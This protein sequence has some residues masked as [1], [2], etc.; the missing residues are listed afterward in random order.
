VTSVTFETATIADAIRRAARIAP[1]KAGHAFDKAAG[2]FMEID[3]TGD[4]QC[5][6]RATNIEAFHTEVIATVASDGEP[7]RWRLPSMLMGNIIGGLPPKSGSTVKFTQEDRKIRI[8]M[9]KMRA[10]MQL[11]DNESYPDWDMFDSSELTM[12]SGL[13]GRVGMVEWAASTDN[14]PPLCGVYLDGQYAVAT[15][16]YRL[17]RVPCRIDKL[18]KPII[19]PS[20]ILG[21]ALKTMGDTGVMATPSQLLLAPDD[22]TQLRL[23]MYDAT[24]PPVHKIFETEYEEVAEVNKTDLLEKISRANQYAGAERNPLLRTFW[25]KGEIAVMMENAEVGIVGDVVECPGFL[26]HP[27]VEINF[28]PKNLTDALNN[29]PEAKVKIHYGRT[30]AGLKLPTIKIDGGAGYEAWVMKRQEAR[31]TA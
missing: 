26:D 24:Y 3:P 30:E 25:G 18:P 9:G 21:Q 17:A 13:G 31:P 1:G 10:S 29:A 27:R 19:I 12:V 14:N 28:T 22:Y 11:I 23:A 4:V 7:A 6:I 20:G 2:I 15:D 8:T 5:L 16:R